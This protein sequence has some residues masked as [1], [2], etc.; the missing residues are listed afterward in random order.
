MKE[1]GKW[2]RETE[3]DRKGGAG[4]AGGE[5]GEGS[6]RNRGVRARVRRCAAAFT[7]RKRGFF[8]HPYSVL[9]KS[10][11]QT[12]SMLKGTRCRRRDTSCTQPSS[13]YCRDKRMESEFKLSSRESVVSAELE[14]G[15]RDAL[16][17]IGRRDHS[18]DSQKRQ[19]P[20]LRADSKRGGGQGGIG[21]GHEASSTVQNRYDI[22]PQRC[23][24]APLSLTHT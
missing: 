7:R 16:P 4:E 20:T 3:R 6:P 14:R 2:G 11:S 5:G 9:T 12:H 10:S 18:M 19:S 22:A 17:S 21:R 23:G 13:P 1:K 15:E 24:N 8:P